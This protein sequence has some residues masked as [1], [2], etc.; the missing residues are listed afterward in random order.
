MLVNYQKVLMNALEAYHPAGIANYI[1]ELAK[2]YNQFYH[3]YYILTEEN[4]ELVMFRLRLSEACGKLL[5]HGMHLLGIEVPDR[6]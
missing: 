6:M 3:E 1:Y 2:L 4:K 5:K